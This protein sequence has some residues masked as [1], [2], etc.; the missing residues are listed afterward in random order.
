VANRYAVKT[1]INKRAVKALDDGLAAGLAR[2]GALT[3]ALATP[4]VPDQ[5]PYGKGLVEKGAWGV[6][7]DGERLDGTADLPRS[8]PRTGFVLV[9]GYPFPARF[10]ERGT[11]HQ[12]ARPFVDPAMVEA[13][14]RLPEEMKAGVA[15]FIASVT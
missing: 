14:T 5:P 2:V 9:V 11:V 6:F 13:L 1:T 7:R 10:N 12:I 15:R 4:H 8:A 3:I